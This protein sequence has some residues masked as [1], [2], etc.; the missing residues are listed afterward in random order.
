MVA[1]AKAGDSAAVA[2]ASTAWYANANDIAAFLHA[3]NPNHWALAE[4]ESMM[5]SHLDLTLQ[6]AVDRLGGH[7]A[8]DVAD[9]DRV[10]AEILEMA[11]MLSEGII[12]QFPQAFAR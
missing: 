8:A 2:T 1:A 9:Y 11:D 3:A 6:E 10:H 4:L 5:K 12:A 7:Y